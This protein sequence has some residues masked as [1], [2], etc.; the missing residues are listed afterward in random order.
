MGYIYKVTNIDNGK[1]YI[2]QTVQSIDRRWK[3]HI[4]D[5]FNENKRD[6][7]NYFHNAIRK[8]GVKS[9]SIEKIEEC[10]DD[11]L[12]DREI[13]WIDFYQSCNKNI[14]YNMTFGGGGAVKYTDDYILKLWDK[15]YSIGEM[16][17][18]SNIDRGWISRRL[19]SAG[20]SQTDINKRRYDKTV[21][22]TSNIVY[23]YDID[24]NYL[25]SYFS[26]NEAYRQTNIAHIENCCNHI[27]R[28]AGGFRWSYEKVDKL[29]PMKERVTS[30]KARQIGR[31]DASNLNL[32]EVYS[33]ASEAGRVNNLN[34]S[35]ILRACKGRQK[36]CGGY[37]WKYIE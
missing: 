36:T 26:L 28:Q 16:H 23:H 27:Q 33:S 30:N 3:Q 19:K 5:S 11:K 13:Y 12:N 24:G 32:L 4:N 6:F 25:A 20:V 14:G 29:P 10:N 15:G 35:N 21:N 18:I 17:E 8:Y 34:K 37:I 22:K 1:V 2:G 31:Y 7:Q 9:F